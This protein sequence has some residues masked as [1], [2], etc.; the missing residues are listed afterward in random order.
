MKVR[1]ARGWHRTALLAVA[2]LLCACRHDA[3]PSTQTVTFWAMGREGES[4]RK[5]MPAFERAH[6]DIHVRVEILPW[7]AAHQ[8]LL[9][10]FAGDV[11]PDL[12]QLGNTWVPELAA[13]GALQPLGARVRGSKRIEPGDYFPGIWDTNR[14]D[15]TLY[16]VPWYV[17]TRLL[18]YRKDLLARAGFDHPPRSWSEWA[19]Q[20]A[21]VK[22]MVGP[23][24]YA[25]LLPLNEF[26]QLESLGL[27]QT[28]SMLRDGGRY[29]NFQS[30]GF[31]HALRFYDEIFRKD[32]APKVTNTE[33]SNPWAEFGRGYF[34]FYVS[35]PW[36]IEEFKNRLPASQQND[37]ATAPLPGPDGPGASLAGGASLVIFR[38]SKHKQA[39]WTLIEYLSR[40]NVQRKFY[41][42]V[43]DMPPRRS[44][45][46]NSA[47]ADDPHARAF[48]VQL[49]RA[50]P[51]PKVPEWE[52]IAAQLALVEERMA[53]GRLSV[54][55]AARTLDE[56]ADAILA[57]RRWVLAHGRSPQREPSP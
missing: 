28:Q 55:Q 5:L 31:K 42:L 15:G 33:V 21:A 32:W 41:Q 40:P 27:Q 53:H 46:D 51:V 11:T 10:A 17:D 44:A 3:P 30:P 14:I 2:L 18:F 23:K 54:D 57:K 48:R 6:P 43:G 39:A 4:V 49:E 45:W 36:N 25:V 56:R 22:A 38:A 35:G 26:E 20:M 16:G 19:R 37:W 13:L 50:R 7:K 52:R 24:R 47:L 8:K 12:C 34:T 1:R 29:G 9:T